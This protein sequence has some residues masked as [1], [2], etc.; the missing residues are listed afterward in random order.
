LLDNLHKQGLNLLE[1]EALLTAKYIYDHAEIAKSFGG[2][3]MVNYSNH[4]DMVY[5]WLTTQS[6]KKD[7]VNRNFAYKLLAKD[8]ERGSTLETM[9]KYVMPTLQSNVRFLRPGEDAIY[10]GFQC[11]AHGHLGKNGARG[12]LKNLM[13]GYTKLIKGHSHEF[14]INDDSINVGTSSMIPMPYQLG[15]PSTSMA[16]N[17]VVYKGGLSQ[18]IPIIKSRWAKKGFAKVLN[19]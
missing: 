2:T 8:I 16:A 17:A 7:V 15:Q 6:W 1:N 12:N 18:G 3:I 4:D 9:L 19:H 13:E 10:W 5:R 14:E 11:A